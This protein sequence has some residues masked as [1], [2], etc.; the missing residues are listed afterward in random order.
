MSSIDNLN[1]AEI[2]FHKEMDE[3]ALEI[4]DEFNL[5]W[6]W[7]H[8]TEK[9][10]IMGFDFEFRVCLSCGRWETNNRSSGIFCADCTPTKRSY[11]YE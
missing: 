1:K 11:P 3:K 5:R 8:I 2:D 6:P 9:D 10:D 4:V 7:K